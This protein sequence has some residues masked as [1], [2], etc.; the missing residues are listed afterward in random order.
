MFQKILL[1]HI[2][3]RGKWTPNYEVPYVVKTTSSDGNLIL[4]IMDGE[5]LPHPEKSNIVK[6]TMYKKL[7]KLEP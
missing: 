1:P 7:A 6:N 2:E 5:E 3:S 4:I